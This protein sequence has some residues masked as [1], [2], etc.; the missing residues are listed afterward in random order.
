MKL[1]NFITLS[2]APIFYAAIVN[3]SSTAGPPESFANEI[4]QAIRSKKTEQRVAVLHPKSRACINSKTQPYFDWIFTRQF[5]YQLPARFKVSSTLLTGPVGPLPDKSA[6][7]VM[8]THQVQIDFEISP[9]SSTSV[10]VLAKHDS[11]RWHEVLPC[12]TPETLAGVQ[13][14]S[15]ESDWKNQRIRELASNINDLLRTEI[16]TMLNAGRR[17]DAIRKY[18]GATGEELV[19]AKGVV[20]LLGNDK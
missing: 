18:A 15:T 6:Y 5:R 1:F 16:L 10:V 14:S 7:P 2:I 11:K 9:T 4:V 8:P 3:A 20:E 12:P 13:K 17:V 19:I